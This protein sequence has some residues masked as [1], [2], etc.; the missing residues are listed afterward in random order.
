MQLQKALILL[1]LLQI[2]FS[3]NLIHESKQ[4]HN[5]QSSGFICCPDTYIFD[6]D[7]LSCICPQST[8]FIDVSGKC[9]ACA[10]P[11]YFDNTTST[12]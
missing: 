2:I 8:P 11:N 12:C 10:H 9:I 3:M 1:A 4:N 7:T 5:D 6:D